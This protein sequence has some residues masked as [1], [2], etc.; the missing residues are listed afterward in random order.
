[1]CWYYSRMKLR[2][3]FATT[4]PLILC[5]FDHFPG[6]SKNCVNFHGFRSIFSILSRHKGLVDYLLPT[7]NWYACAEL[8]DTGVGF[9]TNFQSLV[10]RIAS[11]VSDPPK[12]TRLHSYL[13][14]KASRGAQTVCFNTYL[15]SWNIFRPHAAL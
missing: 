13:S 6:I 10:L 9:A 12:L 1:M 4:K 15:R 3:L 5:A 11:F 14:C 2:E 8:N 7:A